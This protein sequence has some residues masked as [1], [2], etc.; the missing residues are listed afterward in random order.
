MNSVPIKQELPLP[1]LPQLLATSVLF[2][3]ST[4]KAAAGISPK[5][6]HTVSVLLC[7]AALTWQG[8]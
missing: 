2:P 1:Y 5:W 4:N 7:L 3:V 8:L 6:D